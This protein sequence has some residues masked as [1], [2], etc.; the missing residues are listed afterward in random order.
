MN[1]LVVSIEDAGQSDAH[2]VGGKGANLGELSR[3]GLPVPAGFVV[4]TRAFELAAGR[5]DPDGSLRHEIA[6]LDPDDHPAVTEATAAIRRR[7]VESGLP[8][9][10]GEKLLERCQALPGA[11]G[12]HE[13]AVAVRSSAV[14]ED[15]PDTSLAGLQDTFLWV[16]GGARVAAK[17]LS[18][19]AS[20]YSVESVCYRLRRAVAEEPAAMA[21]VV[22]LMVDARSSGVMFTR[23]PQS[24]DRSVVAVE[25]AWGLGS[26]VVGGAVTPDSF[27]LS[28]VTGEVLRRRVSV[29]E[30]RHV[31]DLEG[32]GV[33]DEELAG[34]L[35]TASSVSDEELGRLLEVG[36]ALEDHY[37]AA[38]DVE[39]AI[40]E[41]RPR[42]ED[43]LLLQSRPETVWS[44]RDTAR[45]A[46][47]KP[48]PFDH[49]IEM[50][51]RT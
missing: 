18:C 44:R 2:L 37:G 13:A 15:S 41:H 22:Q 8:E 9:T 38:Q 50:L 33:R 28:K 7:V 23:S 3:L 51:G 27:L 46:A 26:A 21:V 11:G 4:T 5:F 31:R 25:S 32:G 40:A 35:R 6:R 10:L 17:V 30:R 42:G 39:W 29:K 16:Q 45:I 49:V 34:E 48:R 20:F 1:D 43:L 36:L 24:G 19:W 12:D 47:A 14:A